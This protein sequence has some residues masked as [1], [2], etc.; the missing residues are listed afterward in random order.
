MEYD[1]WVACCW[2]VAWRL[3]QK[4]EVRRK[5]KQDPDD[6]IIEKGRFGSRS[7]LM[8]VEMNW[9]GLHWNGCRS[10]CKPRW[11]GTR[12]DL[13]MLIGKSC[14]GF[15]QDWCLTIN[16]TWYDICIRLWR[17]TCPLWG[18]VPPS[19]SIHNIDYASVVNVMDF[20][21]FF[22]YGTWALVNLTCSNCHAA[23]IRQGRQ[24]YSPTCICF[25]SN[26][27][28]W[29]G[30]L[31]L[32]ASAACATDLCRQDGCYQNDVKC[33]WEGYRMR[34]NKPL[35]TWL[36]LCLWLLHSVKTHSTSMASCFTHT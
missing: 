8:R 12:W 13:F 18:F 21:T 6:H 35:D 31:H 16:V 29:V 30:G 24:G 19:V 1:R 4:L 33:C 9:C 22:Q 5:E 20:C 3:T 14:D 28:L 26:W 25:N 17:I 36:L 27:V 2:I 7:Q 10:C 34:P 15:A 23:H 11:E 32:G